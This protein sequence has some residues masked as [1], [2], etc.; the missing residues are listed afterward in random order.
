MFTLK[1]I[2]KNCSELKE[3]KKLYISAF[4]KEERQPFFVLNFKKKSPPVRIRASA[5]KSAEKS[6]F[7]GTFTFLRSLVFLC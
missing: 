5:P 4:P 6:R 2:T 3:I 7:L 1:K